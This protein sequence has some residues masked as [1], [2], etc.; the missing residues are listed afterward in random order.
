MAG[1]AD[2]TADSFETF[3]RA[4]TDRVYRSLALADP[5]LTPEALD[6]AMTRAYARW[7]HVAS[8]DNSGG[9][10]FRV[11]LN[12]ATS[13]W[14]KL[15]RERPLPP[16]PGRRRPPGT[17]FPGRDHHSRAPPAPSPH[18]HGLLRRRLRR[19][20]ECGG[21]T[22]D[23]SEGGRAARAAARDLDHRDRLAHGQRLPAKLDRC[24]A[25]A[26]DQRQRRHVDPCRR[27]HQRH[28]RAHQLYRPRFASVD[29]E[30]RVL[31]SGVSTPRTS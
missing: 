16:G 22:S 6:E 24:G 8:L 15:R 31:V 12:W 13:R 20:G 14:R 11:G 30:L 5:H 18:H 26:D 27:Q 2:A 3:Y 4:Q 25:A 1:A 19:P 10:V 23:N 9:W 29:H 28:R 21:R 7:R 17:P